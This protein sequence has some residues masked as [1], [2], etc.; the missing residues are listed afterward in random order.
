MNT[1]KVAAL[2]RLLIDMGA[3]SKLPEIIAETSCRRIGIVHGKTVWSRWG[4]VLCSGLNAREIEFWE[5][6]VSRR[7]IPEDCG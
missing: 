4:E 3:F 5:T 6:A 2:P 1:I 7:T